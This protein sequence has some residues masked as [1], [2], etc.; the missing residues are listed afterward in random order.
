MTSGSYWQEAN[1]C[2]QEQIILARKLVETKPDID[3]I[4]DL[5]RLSQALFFLP[6]FEDKP[7]RNHILKNQISSFCQSQFI[8][9][10][11]E[12]A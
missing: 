12:I 2:L 11:V 6:Y 3:Q 7:E 10:K 4:V 8:Q 1:D 5:T 9:K